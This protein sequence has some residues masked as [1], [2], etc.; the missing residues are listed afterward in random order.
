M[1]RRGGLL[2]AVMAV[3]VGFFSAGSVQ[4]CDGTCEDRGTHDWVWKAAEAMA[5]L[6]DIIVTASQAGSGFYISSF[7]LE[8]TPV[9]L[10]GTNAEGGTILSDKLKL[11]ETTTGSYYLQIDSYSSAESQNGTTYVSTSNVALGADLK[12]IF[13]FSANVPSTQFDTIYNICQYNDN[14]HFKLYDADTLID[15]DFKGANYTPSAVPVP[16]SALLLG[17]SILGL[18][19]FGSRRKKAQAV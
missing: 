16:S 15:I 10:I 18:A 4:A 8:G 6:E 12:F 5:T 11:R 2:V 3:L 14:G 13:G 9:T 7:G 1:K 19:G 17:S